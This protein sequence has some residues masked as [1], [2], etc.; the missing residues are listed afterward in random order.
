[1]CT[2]CGL[3]DLRAMRNVVLDM[4]INIRIHVDLPSPCATGRPQPLPP[5]PILDRPLT[6]GTA[7]EQTKRA[8]HSPSRSLSTHP[9]SLVSIPPDWQ[10]PGDYP[11]FPPIPLPPS[12]HPTLWFRHTETHTLTP[13][14]SQV[15]LMRRAT[16]PGSITAW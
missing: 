11:T 12:A 3:L 6:R 16:Q 8:L 2:C 14:L 7:S 15:E 4:Y 1:M 9:P 5:Y 13:P 10:A